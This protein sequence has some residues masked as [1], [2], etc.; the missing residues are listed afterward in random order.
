MSSLKYTPVSQ[1]SN[2]IS[3]VR[4]TFRSGK[5]QPY[6]WREHQLRQLYRL[7][8]EKEKELNDA[9]YKDLRKPSFEACLTETGFVQAEVAHTLQHLHEWMKPEKPSVPLVNALDNCYIQRQPYGVVFIIGAWN[10]PIQLVLI[11]LIGAIA[12]GNASILKPSELSPHTAEALTRLLPQYL[13]KDAIQVING[14]VEETSAALKERFDYIFYTGSTMVGRIIMSAAAKYLTPVTLELGG[15]CPVVIDKDIDVTSTAQRIAW[16]KF[17]NSGQSCVAPDY[18]LC[19]KAVV[20]DVVQK[21][22]E[23]I[24]K[25][26]GEDPQKSPDFGRIVNANHFGRIQKLLDGSKVAYGGKY[27]AQDLYISPTVLID[28]TADSPIMSSEIFGPV[29]PVIAVEDIDE[30]IRFI[31]ERERPLA[32]YA[33]S[34]KQKVIDQVFGNT[35]SGGAVANDV[36]MHLSVPELPF[37]GIGESGVGAYHGRNSFL[38]FSHS[39]AVMIK[40]MGLEF[41]NTLRYAPYSVRNMNVLKKILFPSGLPSKSPLGRIALFVSAFAFAAAYYYGRH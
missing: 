35:H 38:T 30:A 18:L 1:I 4:Q 17:F 29:L 13:D 25:F 22:G 19:H 11:P 32:L 36:M 7:V 41:V 23:T 33:F 9:V 2:I 28:V 27:D 24:R 3:S 40:P 10:Y 21:I 37:G 34:N 5:T 8:T 31:N 6:E 12:A 15:K 39:K 26:Y 14:A 20:K 16:G